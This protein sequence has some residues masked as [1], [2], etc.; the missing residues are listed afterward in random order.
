[1][2]LNTVHKFYSFVRPKLHKLRSHVEF[3]PHLLEIPKLFRALRLS[4]PCRSDEE[5]VKVRTELGHRVEVSDKE[6]FQ[7]LV[8][9]EYVNI[10][11]DKFYEGDINKISW[12]AS[13][14]DLRQELWKDPQQLEKLQ[15]AAHIAASSNPF[16]ELSPRKDAAEWEALRVFTNY[17]YLMG[18]LL[19]P[20]GDTSVY[21]CVRAAGLL[22]G[23]AS[24]PAGNPAYLTPPTQRRLLVAHLALSAWR[25]RASAS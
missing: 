2:Q 21:T 6:E 14:E 19:R 16:D 15:R 3:Q 12:L 10:F 13:A 20:R 5:Y 1:M 25:A 9:A 8:L 7:A 18:A 4:Y 24:I 22:A 17:V 23:Y 11:L